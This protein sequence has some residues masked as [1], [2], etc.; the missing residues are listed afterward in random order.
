M[1]VPPGLHLKSIDGE[2]A[3]NEL[4]GP[5]GLSVSASTMA[6]FTQAARGHLWVAVDW[7]DKRV[8]APSA[9][10]R[11]FPDRKR[12]LDLYRPVPYLTRDMPVHSIG[13]A[14]S[15]LNLESEEER[16]WR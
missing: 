11:Q 4:S 8:R 2:T 13:W 16:W 5:T 9:P 6:A 10:N 15:A 3:N 14:E 7:R 1:A 12:Q